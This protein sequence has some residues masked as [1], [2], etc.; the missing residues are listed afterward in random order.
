MRKNGHLP[1]GKWP[2]K[3]PKLYR[4]QREDDVARAAAIDVDIERKIRSAA[5]DVGVDLI[6]AVAEAG[7]P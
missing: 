6:I 7:D 4:L 1:E 3:T 5:V 2:F